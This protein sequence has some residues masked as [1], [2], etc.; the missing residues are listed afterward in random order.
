MPNTAFHLTKID[1]G[2]RVL[3]LKANIPITYCGL[4]I[5]AGTRDEREDEHGIAH[6]IEHMMFKGTE[7]RN[8]MQVISRLEDIGGELNAYTTKEETFV[9]SIVPKEHTERAV[10]LLSD[11]V[12]NSTFPERQ[13][14]K[15]RKVV[16]EEIDM[17]QD[18]PS[19]Q[20]YDDFEDMI[21]AGSSLGHNILGSKKS[22]LAISSDKCREFVRRCYTT[23]NI[24]FFIYGNLAE[25]EVIKLAQKHLS[26]DKTTRDFLRSCPI[27][28]KPQKVLTDK[29]T[30][31]VHCLIGNKTLSLK[32]KDVVALNLLNNI[33]GGANL[34]SRLNL[35]VRERYGW[36]YSIES[37]LSLYSDIGVWGVYFGCSNDKYNKCL[38]LVNSELQRLCQMRISDKQLDMYRQQMKGQ[39]LIQTQNAENYL[40]AMAKQALHNDR[41]GSLKNIFNSIDRVSAEDIQ[42][43]SQQL[44]DINQTTSLTYLTE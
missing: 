26:V 31:Q 43:L 9:Y 41:V 30:N 38:S 44:F 19:E 13:L 10:E 14:K 39:L 1:N 17:Y 25:N 20:I 32:S 12:F 37:S 7:K 42:R 29:D 23:D 2:I 28:Y 4:A 18:S 8:S 3:Y 40:L 5:N 35:A 24:L 21:F 16:L 11:I 27:I 34:T 6:L 33:L 15:E 22:L 36:V